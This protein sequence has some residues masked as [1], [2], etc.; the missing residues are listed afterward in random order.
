V[1]LER[2][3]KQRLSLAGFLLLEEQMDKRG[4]GLWVV[5][6]SRK[7][8][9]ESGLGRDRVAGG[10]GELSSQEDIVGGFG[11]EPDRGK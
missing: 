3:G 11:G 1:L 9:P 2:S 8:A 10:L 7:Q 6:V 4:S 5:R